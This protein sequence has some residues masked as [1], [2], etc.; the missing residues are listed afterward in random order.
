MKQPTDD[1]DD[2]NALLVRGADGVV[3]P[4]CGQS[5]ND[6][7]PRFPLFMDYDG[8]YYLPVFTPPYPPPM[9]PRLGRII[10]P[11]QYKRSV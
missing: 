8:Q 2:D 3:P 5:A 7:T 4:G 10:R 6:D 11:T 1:S 9:S